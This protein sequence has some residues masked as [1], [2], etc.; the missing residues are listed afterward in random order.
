M[1]DAL[2]QCCY[3]QR[4][5]WGQV[6]AFTDEKGGVQRLTYNARGQVSSAQDCS[7]KTTQYRYDEAY[8]LA[9]ETDAAGESTHYE[10]SP[11]GRLV[12]VL[13]AEGHVTSLSWTPQGQPESYREGFSNPV[14]WQYDAA[15]NQLETSQSGQALKH[16]QQHQL[17]QKA[18]VYDVYGRLIQGLFLCLQFNYCYIRKNPLHL[19]LFFYKE[20]E[21]IILLVDEH[22]D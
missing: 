15:G 10:Y 3:Y 12:K 17:R 8:R 14:R 6:T 20:L 18:C 13:R 11:A 21:V 16:N 19:S 5:A 1:I 22:S 2:G 7:G 4:D 9:E